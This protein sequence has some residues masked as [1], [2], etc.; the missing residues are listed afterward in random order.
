MR[1][2]VMR[3]NK[4][5]ATEVADPVP[6]LGEVLVETVACGI[7]GS[8]LHTLRHTRE[9]VETSKAS[10]WAIYGMATATT[11]DNYGIWGDSDSPTGIGTKGSSSYIGMFGQ[12][13]SLLQ[14]SYGVYSQGDFGGT[15]MPAQCWL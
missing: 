4:L 7:C 1:A 8:D 14:E 13:W 11:G 2:A 9:F 12:G 10:G 6:G 5:V 15:V 3:K